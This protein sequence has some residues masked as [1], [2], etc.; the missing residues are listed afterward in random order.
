MRANVMAIIWPT[1]VV[2]DAGISAT[3]AAIVGKIEAKYCG[4]T[5]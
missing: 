2:I 5:T 1:I 4:K 3:M